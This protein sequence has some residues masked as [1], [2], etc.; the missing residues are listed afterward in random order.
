MAA[1][2]QHMILKNIVVKPLGL[3]LKVMKSGVGIPDV[4]L[5]MSNQS[6]NQQTAVQL[7]QWTQNLLRTMIV[8]AGLVKESGV[9]TGKQLEISSKSTLT[10]QKASQKVERLLILDD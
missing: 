1:N 8:A 6:L 5:L 2:P 3:R 4:R 7:M 10:A 9:R